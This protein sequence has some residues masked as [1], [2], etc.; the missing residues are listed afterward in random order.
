MR[1]I[2]I[3]KCEDCPYFEY[4]YTSDK[5]LYYCEQFDT[6]K[7]GIIDKTIIQNWCPL[8]EVK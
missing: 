5:F 2:K 1:I 6:Y 7:R 3:S 4:G 8:E